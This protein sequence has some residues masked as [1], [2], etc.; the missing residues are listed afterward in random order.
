MEVDSDISKI[1]LMYFKPKVFYV[2]A[3][4][5]NWNFADMPKEIE[6]C[7]LNKMM[8]TVEQK[9]FIDIKTGNNLDFLCKTPFVVLNRDVYAYIKKY[10]TDFEDLYKLFYKTWINNYNN[11]I[12]LY[13]NENKY[14]MV[15]YD[16]SERDYTWA[17]D[18]IQDLNQLGAIIQD[19]INKINY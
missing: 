9:N 11:Q 1:A 12:N 3:S 13:I 2:S 10:T 15:W 8:L 17:M 5:V 4:S 6:G 19:E 7:F 14:D 18:S 16:F